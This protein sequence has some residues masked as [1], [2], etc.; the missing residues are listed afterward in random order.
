[1]FN[2]MNIGNARS[3]RLSLGQAI[4]TLRKEHHLTQQRLAS[5][6]GMSRTTVWQLESG[7]GTLTV[8]NLL[9]VA[10]AL[11]AEI[12]IEP[13][14]QGYGDLDSLFGQSDTSPHD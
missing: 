6:A 10:A 2:I 1:M 5:A 3:G 11:S 12:R 8:D 14:Q 9:A 13:R 4:R 7:R